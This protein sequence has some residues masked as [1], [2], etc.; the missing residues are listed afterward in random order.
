MKLCPVCGGSTRLQPHPMHRG[1]VWLPA[2]WIWSS[3]TSS[4]QHPPDSRV[5]FACNGVGIVGDKGEVV[6]TNVYCAPG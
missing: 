5:C 2:V 4:A 1:S 3:N 6:A